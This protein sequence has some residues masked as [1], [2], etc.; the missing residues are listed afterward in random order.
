MGAA[1]LSAGEG[2]LPGQFAPPTTTTTAPPT[3]T[4][5]AGE[6]H[7]GPGHQHDGTRRHQHHDAGRL[8]LALRAATRGPKRPAAPAAGTG[9]TTTT[10]APAVA[11]SVVVPSKDGQ[12]LYTLGPVGLHR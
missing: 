2:A 4:T 8:E 10:T 9:S 7:D 3:T 12:L 1:G 11:G 6:H 5:T